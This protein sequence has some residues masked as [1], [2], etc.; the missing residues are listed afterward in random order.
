MDEKELAEIE[1]WANR[2]WPIHSLMPWFKKLLAE[3]RRLK[4]EN[5]AMQSRLDIAEGIEVLR[6]WL[7]KCGQKLIADERE[8]IENSE[9]SSPEDVTEAKRRIAALEGK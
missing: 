9:F 6:E 7:R 4:A 5:R 8:I 2:L 3:V 1:E